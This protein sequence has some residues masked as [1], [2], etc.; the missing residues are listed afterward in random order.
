M[1]AKEVFI[2]N[3]LHVIPYRSTVEIIK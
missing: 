1:K 3:V 2:L